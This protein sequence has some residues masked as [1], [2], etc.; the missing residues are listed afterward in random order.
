M[1]LVISHLENIS[2][3]SFAYLLKNPTTL[4]TS[5]V[6]GSLSLLAI[7]RAVLTS[8]SRRFQ[9][10]VPMYLAIVSDMSSYLSSTHSDKVLECIWREIK[11]GVE[12]RKKFWCDCSI[13][14]PRGKDDYVKF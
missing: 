3:D 1:A 9:V 11:L 4:S 10:C 7:P 8:L 2:Y 5:A 12:P 6:V 14:I 13:G